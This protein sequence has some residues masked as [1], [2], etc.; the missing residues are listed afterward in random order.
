MR[1]A[2]DYHMQ[3]KIWQTLVNLGLFEPTLEWAMYDSVYGTSKE[4]VRVVSSV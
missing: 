3:M 4:E 2:V 1:N